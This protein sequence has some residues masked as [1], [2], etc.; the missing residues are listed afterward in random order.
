MAHEHVWAAAAPY[1]RARKNDVHAL[2]RLRRDAPAGA[3][4]ILHETGWAVIAHEVESARIAVGCDFFGLAPAE[5]ADHME[6]E[7]DDVM[8]TDTARRIARREIAHTREALRL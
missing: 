5:Y 7:L 8:F 3:P 4:V 6:R 1:L 2:V